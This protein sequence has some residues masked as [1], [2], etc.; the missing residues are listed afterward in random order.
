[1]TYSIFMITFV[2][3]LHEGHA[4]FT[5][6]PSL[7]QS[8]YFL[9]N[10]IHGTNVSFDIVYIPNPSVWKCSDQ[11]TELTEEIIQGLENKWK[12]K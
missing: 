6:H 4:Y 11:F 12:G 3:K 8:I 7:A 1:M 5:E 2:D 9:Y 10:D